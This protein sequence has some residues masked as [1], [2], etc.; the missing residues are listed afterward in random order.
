MIKLASHYNQSNFGLQ[1]P[2]FLKFCKT[3][4]YFK[5]INLS[6]MIINNAIAISKI[7]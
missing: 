2:D 6:F 4:K 5:K 7:K 3:V 1:G